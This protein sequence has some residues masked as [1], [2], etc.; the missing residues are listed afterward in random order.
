MHQWFGHVRD[1]EI[2]MQGVVNN[3]QYLHYFEHARHT[4]LRE[5]GIDFADWHCRKL[6]FVLVEA[7]LL[8][9]KP[10]RSGNEFSI[11]TTMKQQGR[12]RLHIQQLLYNSQNELMTTGNFMATC[13]D[14]QRGKACLPAELLM[15]L[16]R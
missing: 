11:A 8:Y 15:L 10:L 7:N 13:I 16:N 12:V 6:D 5:Y 4:M 9:K 14:T 2:D 1:Y 3:A